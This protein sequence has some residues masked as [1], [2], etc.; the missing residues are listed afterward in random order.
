MFFHIG[1]TA[2][3]NYPCHW[4]LGSFSISTDQG[5]QHTAV[6]PIQLLY[7]GYVDSVPIEDVLEQIASQTTPRLTGNFCVLA[8]C[9]DT[10]TIQT[11]IYRSFPIYVD[12]FNAVNN[13]IPTTYIAW[14][15]SLVTVHAD[16]AVTESKF[17]VIGSIPSVY[18]TVSQIDQLLALK[19]QQFAQHNTKPIRVFLSGGIDTLLVYSYI[20]RF[21]IPHELIWNLHCDLDRFYLANHDDIQRHWGYTQIHHWQDACVLASGA[22]GDEFML[23]SPTT[24]NM[25]LLHNGTTIPAELNNNANVLH[26]EYFLRSK[27]VD[28]FDQQIKDYTPKNSTVETYWNLCNTVINDWQHWHLGN[29]LTW[30]PLRDLE[31]FKLFLQLPYDLAHGQIMDSAVSQQLIENNVPGLTTVISD[32]KNSNNC[33]KNLQRLL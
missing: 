21:N 18:S 6:G 4:Q 26:R 30:T 23:R 19:F 29:T 11:D 14:T 25:Y 8:V 17:D 10:L 16:F 13:L 3:E 12:Q 22:P 9:N 32:Q 15:D 28:L 7:K 27:H 1:K 20:R 5:W 31:L 2:Q 24:A 33:M